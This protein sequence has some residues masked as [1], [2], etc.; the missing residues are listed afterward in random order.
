MN[1]TFHA[2]FD[3][4]FTEIMSLIEVILE[5]PKADNFEISDLTGIG[6]GKNASQGKVQ[7]TIKWAEFGGLIESTYTNE[8]IREISLSREGKIVYNLDPSLDS[9]ITAW[10]F[11]YNLSKPLICFEIDKQVIEELKEVLSK[12]K[13]F[14]LEEKLMNIKFSKEKILDE[15]MN[16]DNWFVLNNKLIEFLKGKLSEEKINFLDDTIKKG[17]YEFS[18][19]SLRNLENMIQFEKIK[20]LNGLFFKKDIVNKLKDLKFKDKEIALVLYHTQSRYFSRKNLIKFLTEAGFNEKE[21]VV[22]LD[23]YNFDKEL[24]EISRHLKPVLGDEKNAWHYFVHKFLPEKYEF[25][26]D[27]LKQG[28]KN[29]FPDTKLS[30]I[31]PGILLESYRNSEGMNS[32][33]FIVSVEKD[34]YCK[35]IP[36]IPN[37]YIVGYILAKIWEREHP[38][39]VTIPFSALNQPNHLLNTMNISENGILK[40]LDKLKSDG[41]IDLMRSVK[42]FQIVKQ[43]NNSS[44]LLEK[45][46]EDL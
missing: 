42:P 25:T 31:N 35:G 43:W 15:L 23:F 40:Y 41:I 22:I 33:N 11:H 34:V 20:D 19:S 14:I 2:T 39:N 46:Y 16:F 1:L 3:L 13:L 24:S 38:D 37:P 4:H 17:K 44:E 28:L 30:S 9:V 18:E 26:L 12:E 10:F 45:A 21:I 6:I 7:P 36:N 8:N 32:L 5:N 29:E 27:N